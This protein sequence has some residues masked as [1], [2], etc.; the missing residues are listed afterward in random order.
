MTDGDLAGRVFVLLDDGTGADAAAV[1]HGL[2]EAGASVVTLHE[3]GGA[4]DG[5][6][7]FTGSP[8]NPIDVDAAQTMATE[9]FGPVDAVLYL[10][11]LPNSADTAVRKLRERYSC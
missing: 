2:A 6:A 11:E 3:E 9:L 7:S 10:S 5:R 1:A 4:P 8:T